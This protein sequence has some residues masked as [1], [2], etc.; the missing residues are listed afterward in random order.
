MSLRRLIIVA[1][2]LSAGLGL[3]GAAQEDS[4]RKRGADDPQTIGLLE[5]SGR[6]LAQVDITVVGPPS[7]AA[8]L[9][10]EDLRIKVGQHRIREF[11]LDRYCTTDNAAT[12]LAGS[13]RQ[14]KVD[15]GGEVVPGPGDAAIDAA[16][17]RSKYMLYFDQPQLTLGGRQNAI[18]L[19]RQLLRDLLHEGDQAMIV[20]NANELLVVEPMTDDI[21]LLV[22]ALDR[23]EN[24]RTQ[25]DTFATQEDSRVADVIDTLNESSMEVSGVQRA[26]SRARRYQME[27]T[28]RAEKSMR[29]LSMTLSRLSDLNPPKAVVYF[30]DTMRSNAGEHYLALFGDRV[31]LGDAALQVISSDSLMAQA[32]FDRI[33]NEAA[34]QGIRFYPVLSQGMALTFDT[35]MQNPSALNGSLGSPATSGARFN[36]TRH[37]LANLASETGGYAFLQ[38][39]GPGKMARRIESD[40]SCLYIAS[41]D[42][43]GL[44][45]DAPLRIVV[46][47]TRDDIRLRSRGRLVI[48][49]ES[50]RATARLLAAFASP[51]SETAGIDL[52]DL[53]TN[54]IPTGYRNGK[55]IGLL[56]LSLP[57]GPL[58]SA[59]WDLGATVIHDERVGAEPSGRVSV[60]QPGVRVIFES[61]LQFK[62]GAYEIVAVAHETG[63]GLVASGQI[64]L[65]WPN[66]KKEQATASPVVIL[67]PAHGAFLRGEKTRRTGSLARPPGEPIDSGRPAALVA[68]VCVNRKK[69][70]TLVVQRRLVGDT[71]VEFPPIELGPEV[72]VCAQIRDLV[73]AN[74][75][76]DG[77]YRYEIVVGDGSRTFY[78]GGRDFLALGPDS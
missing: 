29:R 54:L 8:N 9:R 35:S 66:M 67:Q 65:D 73:P 50:A 20:S 14:E 47:P 64:R 74:S 49:S 41:F 46:E 52:F 22:A 33:I 77:Y 1:L 62:P 21:E 39:Q 51:D 11:I 13:T 71:E 70:T 31:R 55:F 63:S 12:T 15:D 2:V 26:I 75:L 36:Q 56:Q 61:E 6:R 34:A 18:T 72:D 25:W 58:Q 38:G 10:V 48:Q 43:A 57:P 78:E 76:G 68:L 17:P 53:R 7:I 32:P 28:W 27:E 42:P 3:R 69:P 23:L 4:G 45:E 59:T 40:F 19:S 37:T 5:R 16:H 24:D 60:P 30:A 44:S